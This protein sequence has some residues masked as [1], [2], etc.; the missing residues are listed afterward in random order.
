VKYLESQFATMIECVQN[1]APEVIVIDEIG[2]KKEAEAARTIAQRGVRL[3]AS[4]HGSLASLVSN[5]ELLGGVDLV[6]VGDSAANK[7]YNGRKNV[8]QRKRESVFQTIIELAPERLSEW[9]IFDD[10]ETKVDKILKGEPFE[11]EI[12][13]LDTETGT[14]LVGREIRVPE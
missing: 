4:A 13:V 2:R 1:H 7:L 9:A 8:Q 12:R 6:T 11:A 5:P 10:V 3:I 14:I